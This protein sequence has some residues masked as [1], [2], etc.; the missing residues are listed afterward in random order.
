MHDFFVKWG[1][2]EEKMHDLPL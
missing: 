2:F 1:I